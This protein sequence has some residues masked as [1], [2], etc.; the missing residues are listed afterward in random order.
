[1]ALA[2]VGVVENGEALAEPVSI[3]VSPVRGV[4]T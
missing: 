3:C 2:S 4:L 1:V